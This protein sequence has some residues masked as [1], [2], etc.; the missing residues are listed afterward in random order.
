MTKMM[1]IIKQKDL[2][3]QDLSTS[4]LME[5]ATMNVKNYRDILPSFPS[6]NKKEK[7]RYDLLLKRHKKFEKNIAKNFDFIVFHNAYKKYFSTNRS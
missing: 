2:E 7:E 3:I 1:K 4:E 6:R 5:L